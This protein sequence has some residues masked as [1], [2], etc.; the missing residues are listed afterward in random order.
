[1]LIASMALS[2]LATAL[3]AGLFPIAFGGAAETLRRDLFDLPQRTVHGWVAT[4]L[5]ALIFLYVAAP[6]YHQLC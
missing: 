3:H 2:G 1:M 6:L 4:A 5:A